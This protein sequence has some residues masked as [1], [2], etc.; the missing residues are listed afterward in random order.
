M[1]EENV[2]FFNRELSWIEFNARV[3]HEARRKD[4][5]L[6]ERL[7]FLSIVTSNFDEFFQVRVASIKRHKM[8]SHYAH[9]GG[10]SGS[11][12]DT[13][14]PAKLLK[15]ISKRAHEL[16]QIQHETLRE[17][18]L[19]ALAKEGIVYV[20]AKDFGAEQKAFTETLFKQEIFP[21]LTPLRADSASF[22]HIANQRLHAAFLLEAVSGIRAKENSFAAKPGAEYILALVQVP[23]S[24]P[25]IVWLPQKAQD[26]K[27]VRSFTV[28][29][30]IILLYG[31]ELFPGYSIKESLLFKV[32]RDADFAVNEEDGNFIQAMQEVLVKRQ[33]SFVVRMVCNA[34]SPRLEKIIREKLSL[35]TDDVYRIH[36][37][38]DLSTLSEIAHIDGASHLKYPE[39]QHFYADDL[40]KDGTYWSTLRE[41]D[42]L[43]HVPYQSYEPV[44]KFI[45][46]AAK[47]EHVLAIKITLY[48]T[49]S[50]SPIVK[51]LEQAARAGK[52]VTAFVELKARFDEQRNISWASELQKA[53]VIVVYGIV[54]VKVHAKLCLVVRRERDGM[55]RYLH[56][57][58]GNYNPKTARIYQD[59]SIFTSN[60]LLAGDAT[61][62]FNVISGYSAIQTMRYLFMAPVTLKS[63]L[64]ELIE[65]EARVSTPDSPGLI[66]AKMNSLCHKEIIEALYKASQAGVTILLNI[67][68]ICTLVPGKK[69]L[70]QNIK[71]VSIIDRYLEHSRIFYFQNGGEE[72]LYMSSADWMERNLDRRVE[73][74][75]PV[76]DR[77]VFKKAKE[78]LQLY[79][80]DNTHSHILQSS[81]QWK[82][83]LPEKK[84]ERVRVQE[85]L[86]K[87]YRHHHDVKKAIPKT[88]FEVRRTNS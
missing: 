19:P 44:V 5:P 35:S 51:A 54:N 45:Q 39:W 87:K 76:T 40:P 77:R 81:G 86:Y 57:S 71:V 26:E 69:G 75:F 42:V 30:D 53:G 46:D 70:S 12:A 22:P 31:S 3:L 11:A 32:N 72:E 48:R 62:F 83:V 10:T 28:L 55:R 15:A 80:E 56:V 14:S 41:K 7:S 60:P 49:G 20:S 67:R 13:N 27:P 50:N 24:V 61:L 65:R 84:E 6:L 37:L 74:M 85:V 34:S 25:R 23:L 66:M 88:E 43:L 73:L 18:I 21:L 1:A 68:G 4:I 79:F 52:Q 16:T 33:S 47:D 9:E 29:D 78:A 58:T 64:L 59:F 17:D 82:E 36:D 2:P 63:K 8:S 38:V